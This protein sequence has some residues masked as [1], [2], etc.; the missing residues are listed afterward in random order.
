MD[1]ISAEALNTLATALRSLLPVPADPTQA[2]DI[3]IQSQ[4]VSPTGLGGFVAVNDNPPGEIFGRRID[5]VCVIGVKAAVVGIDA[6]AA[7]I[8]NALL[9]A[10]R[11]TLLGLGLL[12][13]SFV[14]SGETSTLTPALVLRPLS[15]RV[16]Y[17]FLKIPTDPEGIIQT[18][19]LD[20]QLQS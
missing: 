7:A 13:I 20:I 10:D 15:F 11:A 3:S 5:A 2:P 18:I 14:S 4:S 9:A 6:A 19:P 12:K 16:L 8:N 1:A 17:E